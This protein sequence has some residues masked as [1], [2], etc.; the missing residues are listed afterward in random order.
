MSWNDVEQRMGE[1]PAGERGTSESVWSDVGDSVLLFDVSGIEQQIR[2]LKG[3]ETTAAGS[4]QP[5]QKVYLY[6]TN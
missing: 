2:N 6:T 4:L 5:W 1:C 3:C